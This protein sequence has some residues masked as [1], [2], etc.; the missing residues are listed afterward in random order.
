MTQITA[1]ISAEA[2]DVYDAVAIRLADAVG[3]IADPDLAA[4]RMRSLLAVHGVAA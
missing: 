1:E 3:L 2:I 4:A